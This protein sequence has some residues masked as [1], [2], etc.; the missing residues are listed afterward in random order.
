MATRTWIGGGRNNVFSAKDWSPAGVPV[1]GD[2]LEMSNGTANMYGGDLTGATFLFGYAPYETSTNPVLNVFSGARVTLTEGF[3]S[4]PFSTTP[5]VNVYGHDTVNLVLLSG[6]ERGL[7]STVNLA[8]HAGMAGT[9]Q[10]GTHDASLTINGAT[11]SW[12]DNTNTSVG[13][14]SVATIDANVI[15]VGSFEM[16]GYSLLS[17]GG[18]VS[19]GQTVALAGGYNAVMIDHPTA[20][21]GTIDWVAAAGAI[22]VAVDLLN[23]T[24]NSY[25][26]S[27]DRLAL[28]AGNR[29]VDR[30]HVN[31]APGAFDVYATST[32]VTLQSTGTPANP[33]ETLLPVHT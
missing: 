11:G 31:A 1:A 3:G 29:I 21:H 20:F 19:H 28:F 5:T 13:Y 26:F 6:Y 18:S 14:N 32:G 4:A 27:N 15:G 24:A 30:L 33:G 22:E 25:L 17:F 9:I 8:P 10:I 23:I 16:G 12:F 7:Q 2:T